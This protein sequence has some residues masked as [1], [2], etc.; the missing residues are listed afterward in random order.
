MEKM[1]ANLMVDFV[2]DTIMTKS[3]CVTATIA[4]YKC[5]TPT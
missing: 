3:M 5:L 1:L 4:E 2:P